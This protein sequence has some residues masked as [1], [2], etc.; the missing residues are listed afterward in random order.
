MAPAFYQ[1]CFPLMIVA[2]FIVC[3]W[4]WYWFYAR[5]KTKSEYALLHVVERITGIK[6]TSSL[7]DKELRGIS[8]E[9]DKL[10]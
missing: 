8:K 10:A 2:T 4:G 6:L 5:G 9:I 1:A 7:L 3:A